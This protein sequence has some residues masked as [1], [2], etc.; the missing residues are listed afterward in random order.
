M[1]RITANKSAAAAKSY[2]EEGLSSQDYYTEKNEIIGLWHGK[3]I[4][5]LGLSN[6]ISKSDFEKLCD[7]INPN[8]DERLTLKTNQERRVEYD[9]TFNVSKSV[10]IAYAL[11]DPETRK[12]ILQAFREATTETMKE[13]ELNMQARI[14]KG[15]NLDENRITGNL[16]YG[17]FI[18]ETSRPVNGISDPHL[19]AHCFVFNATFDHVENQWKAAQIG[20]IKK[21]APYYEAVFHST[22]ASKLQKLGYGI[23]K[24]EKG[25]EISGVSRETIEKYSRRTTEIEKVAKEKSITNVEEKA[26]LGATTRDSKRTAAPIEKQKEDWHNRLEPHEK[27]ALKNLKSFA[28][29]KKKDAASESV[30]YSLAHNLERKSVS[31]DKEIL[32]TAL[33][34]SYGS[35]SPKEVQQSLAVRTDVITVKDKNRILLTTKDA[36][37]EEKNIL[38]TAQSFK[39]SFK[40]INSSYKTKTEHLTDEQKL[41]IKHILSSSDGIAVLLGKAGTGKT[42]LMK[43]VK[44]GIEESKKEIFAFAPSAEASRGVQR[45]EGF[46]NAQTIASLLAS[47][48]IQEQTKNGIIW[49]DEAGM[50]SNRDMNGILKVAKQQNARLILSGDTKQH[51]SVERGDALRLLQEKAGFKTVPVT[52]IQRQKNEDYKQAVSHLSKGDTE[53][54]FAKLEKSGFI[55]EI[56]DHKERVA[57]VAAE[58]VS[59]AHPVSVAGNTKKREVLVVAPTHAEGDV[60]TAKIRE[61]LQAVKVLKT[62]E[63]EI[64]TLKSMQLSHAEKCD[65][66]NYKAGD[67]LV[68][69]QNIKGVK[70]GQKLEIKGT[71]GKDSI[72]LKGEKDAELKVSVNQAEHFNPYSKKQLAIASGEKIRITGNGK[73]LEG[74]HLFNGGLY[75][76][77]G[78]DRDG[79]LR[80]SN[81]STLSKDYGHLTHG[82]VS[83]SHSSQGKTVDKVIISQ[84]SMSFRASSLEQFYVSVSRGR[85]AVSIYT[86]DKIGLKAAVAKS[87]ERTGA[88][89]LIE[90]AKQKNLE[91]ARKNAYD[92]LKIRAANSVKVAKQKVQTVA[93]KIISQGNKNG[94]REQNKATSRPTVSPR[95]K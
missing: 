38:E 21:D 75:Q 9:F 34:F 69:H 62:D 2:F 42:T 64:T 7:N 24:T 68:F 39:G 74:K 54:G 93:Q 53:K 55:K 80:L 43:E 17:E 86:D 23:E 47:K 33:K 73:T 58:Y 70:A 48:K 44:L 92:A 20:D 49:I 25:F 3:A 14:R 87:G 13:V 12:E 88:I 8:T 82:Y 90:K 52:R 83:T 41:A 84:S 16:V 72:I 26:K 27:N 77:K 5:K 57:A 35:A 36:L 1:L 19:H 56:E 61:K 15:V 11:G 46:G 85:N 79:N 60:V 29:E 91:V 94:V 95:G 10:S 32:A 45:S 78:F 40:P 81:G 67:V 71:D 18:H 63:K 65:I 51:S 4:Q 22:L 31:N 37:K 6:E 66:G 30:E 28:V 89:E 76:V 59:S 50:V